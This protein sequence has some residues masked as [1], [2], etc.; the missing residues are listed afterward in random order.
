MGSCCSSLV[1]KYAQHIDALL[2]L[3]SSP[4]EMKTLGGVLAQQDVAQW[5][6]RVSASDMTA[7]ARS[8]PHKLNPMAT[9]MFNKIR[10][11][12][13]RGRLR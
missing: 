6:M 4:S 3:P 7:Y 9:Y 13:T 1:P 10:Q 5:K 11:E 12:L 8:M 2:P